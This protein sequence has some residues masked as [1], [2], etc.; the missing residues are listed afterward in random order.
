MASS[1][2]VITFLDARFPGLAGQLE[3]CDGRRQL[4]GS[5][6]PGIGGVNGEQGLYPF[7]VFPQSTPALSLAHLLGLTDR[8]QERRLEGI[9]EG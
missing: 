4:P 8:L 7:T 3:M 9:S 6:T 2:K 5:A 1:D